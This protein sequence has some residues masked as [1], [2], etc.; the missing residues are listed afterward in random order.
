MRFFE[1]LAENYGLAQ[2]DFA[3][4]ADPEEVRAAI[5]QYRSLVTR[6]QFAG[7]ERDINYWRSQGW[8][9]FKDRVKSVALRP[10]ATQLKRRRVEG[11]SITLREDS[12]WL[13]VV[14]LDKNA[15]CFHGRDSEWCTATT[16]DDNRFNQYFHDLSMTLVYCIKKATGQR[17]A[18]VYDNNSS[19]QDIFD[20]NDNAISGGEFQSQTGLKLEELEDLVYRYG[21]VGF[22]ARKDRVEDSRD[23]DRV[24]NRREN[25]TPRSPE[26]EAKIVDLE[27]DYYA[28]DYLEA[29]GKNQYPDDLIILAI[30]P[31]QGAHY[32][33][34]PSEIARWFVYQ[35]QPSKSL[36]RRA[37]R[38]NPPVAQYVDGLDP[39]LEVEL[40][41]EN[42]E[43]YDLLSAPSVKAQMTLISVDPWKFEKIKNPSKEVQEAAIRAQAGNIRHIENP[44]EYLQMLAVEYNSEVTKYINNPSYAVIKVAVRD[45]NSI[46]RHIGSKFEL[47]NKELEDLLLSETGALRF[48]RGEL[49]T[50]EIMDKVIDQADDIAIRY[51]L[52]NDSIDPAR[53]I[54]QDQWARAVDIVTEYFRV[55]FAAPY[56]RIGMIKKMPPEY[57]WPVM[58]SH[59]QHKLKSEEFPTAHAINQQSE[60]WALENELKYFLKVGADHAPPA[61]VSRI[62]EYLSSRQE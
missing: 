60:L 35:S 24:F 26:L 52:D 53:D 11:R 16:S 58:K 5:D 61:A 54:S 18:V 49:L 20:S 29:N 47:S 44:S 4:S 51:I 43:Y 45:N 34:P 41:E 39:Q 27:R 3:R 17:W 12:T 46:A 56:S 23:L 1:I 10:T 21:G 38:K 50:P 6:N 13:I 8:L 30:T 15:S 32:R 33:D 57:L 55:D 25:Y 19:L 22:N 40:I 48:I 62:K 31:S 14:P 59:W 7:Q 37:V 36:V 9:K 42:P 2:T 28:R